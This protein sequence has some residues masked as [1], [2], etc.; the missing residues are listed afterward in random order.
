MRLSLLLICLLSFTF[1]AHSQGSIQKNSIGFVVVSEHSEFDPGT[2][3]KRQYMA[4]G[5]EYASRFNQIGI[6]SGFTLTKKFQRF[7]SLGNFGDFFISR[8]D[9][10]NTRFLEIPISVQYYPK[11]LGSKFL[12]LYFSGGVQAS[13]GQ[14][15]L[16]GSSFNTLFKDTGFHQVS[17]LGLLIYLGKVCSL[18]IQGIYKIQVQ[19][20][21]TL[22]NRGYIYGLQTKL[23]YEF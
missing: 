8:V 2:N 18:D 20:A 6:R 23:S 3:E 1:Q 4:L 11:A 13:F 21:K 19:N 14:D 17:G 5:L 9:T 15:M 16:T 10:R 12:Q 7:E 22:S